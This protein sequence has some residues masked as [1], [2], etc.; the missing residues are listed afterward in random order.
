MKSSMVLA[1]VILLI[2]AAT[3]H[4]LRLD[5]G[6]H[7]ALNNEGMLN[8]KW[9]STANRPIDTRRASNDRRGPDATSIN[10]QK[11]ELDHL[12]SEENC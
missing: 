3:A 2:M 1:S 7:A 11:D 12:Q 5:M 6:L 9:Q 10:L 4:G 8:S